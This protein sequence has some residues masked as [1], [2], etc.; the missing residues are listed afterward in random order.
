MP[1]ILTP[2]V[3]ISELKNILNDT[4]SG[5]LFCFGT[6]VISKIIQAKTRKSN[7][8]KVPSHVAMVYGDNIYEST[9]DV[10][11]VGYKT[12]K[13]GVRRWLIEDFIKAE[14]KK[15]TEYAVLKLEFFVPAWAD[16]Y[17]HLPYGKD[18]ILDFLL[19]D[20]SD[21]DSHGLIC[22]QYVNL[23]TELLP[24]KKC[25]NPA[26]LYRRAKELTKSEGEF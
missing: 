26:E 5:I 8:E 2:I 21:G 6:S 15:Q 13:S 4:Y 10:V 11:H 9:T 25:P 16:K 7:K 19:K 20:G 17:I 23:V 18:T 12:I 1:E 22:S 24:N 14:Y 3:N